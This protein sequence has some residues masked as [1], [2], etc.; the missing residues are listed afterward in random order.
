M[1]KFARSWKDAEKVMTQTME[2]STR[3]LAILTPMLLLTYWHA[4]QPL[5]DGC[6]CV[7]PAPPQELGPGDVV[8]GVDQ[9]PKQA[10]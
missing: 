2:P 3:V 6:V 4:Q 7:V 1:V 9:F 5:P 10:R 8:R